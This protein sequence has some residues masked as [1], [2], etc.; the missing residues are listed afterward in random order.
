[1]VHMKITCLK[2]IHSGLVFCLL[3]TLLSFEG[4]AEALVWKDLNG[5]IVSVDAMK[6]KWVIINLWATWCPPCLDEIPDLM[7]FHD[8][9]HGKDAEVIGIATDFQHREDVEKFVDDMLISYPV[10]LSS[11]ATRRFTGSAEVLPTTL[12]ISPKGELVTKHRGPISRRKLE[13][14]IETQRPAQ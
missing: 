5:H 13:S 4:R 14:L 10:V 8:K 6:G 2:L 12:I 1:M 11:N 9:H 3:L 7:A